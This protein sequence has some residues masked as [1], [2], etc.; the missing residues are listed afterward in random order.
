MNFSIP[1]QANILVC[2]SLLHSLA[3][4][5]VWLVRATL[6]YWFNLNSQPSHAHVRCLLYRYVL[7]MPFFLVQE[8]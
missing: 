3:G 5:A 1:L 2:L 8:W 6:L 7:G 4:H